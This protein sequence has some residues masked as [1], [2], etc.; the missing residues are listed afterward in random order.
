MFFSHLKWLDLLVNI[1][2]IRTSCW[3]SPNC[4]ITVFQ[5]GIVGT[6][7][8]VTLGPCRSFPAVEFWVVLKCFPRINGAKHSIE[9]RDIRKMSFQSQDGLSGSRI[10][11]WHWQPPS[12]H[13]HCWA[14]EEQHTGLLG[15]TSCQS[16]PPADKQAVV[17]FYFD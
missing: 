12:S 15:H 8:R 1:T 13:P 7:P 9:V 6:G 4:Q 5:A 2:E 16:P 14:S 11:G 10:V 3:C 17:Y